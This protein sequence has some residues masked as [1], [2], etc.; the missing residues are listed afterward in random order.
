MS[1]FHNLIDQSGLLPP[2]PPQTVGARAFPNLA[3]AVTMVTQHAH[4]QWVA[5]AHGA[6]LPNGQRI[7]LRSGGYKDSIKAQALGALSSRV[8]SDASY[9]SQIENG[10]PARDLKAMLATAR[11][12]RRA[13]DGSRYLI[14]PFRW[15]T[16][17]TQTFGPHQVMPESVHD[18]WKSPSMKRSAMTGMGWRESGNYPGMMVEQR[19]YHWGSRLAKAD[20]LKAGVNE[21]NAKR[22]AGMVNMRKPGTSGG[23][24]QSHYMTFRVLSDKSRGWQTPAGAGKHPARE[25][26]RGFR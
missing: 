3:K 6:P 9:A 24:S 1:G 21:I 18:L 22:M 25:L 5:W 16:P 17:G 7:G 14:I 26:A 13:K 8:Y 2:L 10:W 19:S 12:V 15:G 20:L 4:A 23:A 11:K